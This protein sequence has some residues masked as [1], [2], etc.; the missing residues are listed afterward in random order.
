V[1]PANKLPT[2]AH[3]GTV[4]AVTSYSITEDELYPYLF[5]G[6]TDREPR[7][8]LPGHLIDKVLLARAAADDALE[9]LTAAA[10]AKYG[11]GWMFNGPYGR[12]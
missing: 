9:E 3:V 1:S 8:S 7:G 11:T 4:A 10:E 2:R 6:E 5:I 12:D